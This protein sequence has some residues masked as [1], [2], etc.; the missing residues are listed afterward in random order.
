MNQVVENDNIQSFQMRDNARQMTS[1]SRESMN[2]AHLN[3]LLNF[4]QRYPP[5]N[6]NLSTSTSNSGGVHID[7]HNTGFFRNKYEANTNLSLATPDIP[8]YPAFYYAGVSTILPSY[9][10]KEG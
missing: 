9:T 6:E 2:V 5:P 8:Y 7:E 1:Y 10:Q 4:Q 3:T